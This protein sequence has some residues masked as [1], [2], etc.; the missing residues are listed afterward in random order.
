MVGLQILL[1]GYVGVQ[2]GHIYKNVIQSEMGTG[3]EKSYNKEC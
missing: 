2:P 1:L 3:H